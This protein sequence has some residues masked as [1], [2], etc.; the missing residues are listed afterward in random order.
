LSKWSSTS[1]LR[2]SIGFVS[3]VG[4]LDLINQP[5]TQNILQSLKNLP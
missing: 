1:G 3:V 4:S 5:L 2:F